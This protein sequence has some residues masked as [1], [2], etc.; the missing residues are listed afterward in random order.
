[1]TSGLCWTYSLGFEYFLCSKN[2]GLDLLRARS[3][4]G[5]PLWRRGRSQGRRRGRRGRRWQMLHGPFIIWVIWTYLNTSA[6]GH[7]N[8]WGSRP[9]KPWFKWGSCGFSMSIFS[10]SIWFQKPTL[11]A[12]KRQTA[13]LGVLAG[14]HTSPD[15]SSERCPVYWCS[16][17]KQL[18]HVRKHMEKHMKTPTTINHQLSVIQLSVLLHLSC[19]LTP[20]LRRT[21]CTFSQASGF[22]DVNHKCAPPIQRTFDQH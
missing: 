10:I 20:C 8:I 14:H 3:A 4:D 21:L 9:S 5:R 7:Q 22:F 11:G 6:G 17:L 13:G 16:N 15:K 18:K 2:P 1:M 12:T 19:Q